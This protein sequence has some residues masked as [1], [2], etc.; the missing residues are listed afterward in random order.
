MQTRMVAG[1][2][3]PT[4]ASSSSIRPPR[5]GSDSPRPRRRPPAL[6][7]SGNPPPSSPR[8][9]MT[10]MT[11]ALPSSTTVAAPATGLAGWPTPAAIPAIRGRSSSRASFRCS[12]T[13][14]VPLGRSAA[15]PSSCG[16]TPPTTS[17][18]IPTPLPLPTASGQ[19][20]SAPANSRARRPPARGSRF[21][22]PTTARTP[23][24]RPGSTR[25]TSAPRKR[26]CRRS[27]ATA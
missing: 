6:S 1:L 19:R 9:P 5:K 21:T 17:R 10:R 27:T 20:P 4:A 3:W 7:T 23:G 2:S 13:R 11:R 24:K 8:A 14:S 12:T 22:A 18:S 26:R 16:A 25:R 15:T